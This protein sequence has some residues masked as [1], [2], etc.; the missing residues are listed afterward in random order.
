MEK[1]FYIINDASKKGALMIQSRIKYNT[2][3]V[4]RKDTPLLSQNEFY[5][6][7][8]NKLFDILGF[9]DSTSIAI[10]KKVKTILEENSITGWGCFPIKIEGIFDEY[11][12]FQVL[13]KAGPILNLDAVNRYETEFSEFDINT[14]DGSDVF[15][16]EATLLKVCTKKVKDALEAAKVTNLEIM[17]L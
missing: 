10:S 3:D 14:W 11:Y 12:A 1:K 5:I 4:L 13:S 6:K 16:L 8:G 9:N 2:L 17:P 15:N 7:S